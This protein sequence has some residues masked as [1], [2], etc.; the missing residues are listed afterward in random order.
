VNFI[1]TV[2]KFLSGLFGRSERERLYNEALSTAERY[3][4]WGRDRKSMRDLGSAA[5]HLGRLNDEDAPNDHYHLRANLCRAAVHFHKGELLTNA[6]ADRRRS[7]E[8]KL[9]DKTAEHEHQQKTLD[10]TDA[11][12]AALK[13]DGSMISAKEE[14]SRRD[15]IAAIIGRFSEDLASARGKLWEEYAALLG[16]VSGCKKTAETALA[17]IE[18][19]RGLSEDDEKVRKGFVPTLAKELKDLEGRMA[20][21]DPNPST[22]AGEPQEEPK[23]G[24]GATP[25]S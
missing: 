22:E 23:A 10:E 16:E 2:M 7:C 13:A 11:K 18:N 25:S 4:K 24:A 8:D 15:D 21:L 3:L 1:K 17:A 19:L 12:I 14:A 9:Q 6:F 5:E 20:A